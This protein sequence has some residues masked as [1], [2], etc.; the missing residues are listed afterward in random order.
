[1]SKCVLRVAAVASAIPSGLVLA[2][3]R[4][5][6]G[7]KLLTDCSLHDAGGLDNELT[8]DPDGR[9]VLADPDPLVDS[10][11]ALQIA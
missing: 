6:F 8:I 1:M 2:T 5:V 3:G 9:L 7:R 11:H 10:V 4:M